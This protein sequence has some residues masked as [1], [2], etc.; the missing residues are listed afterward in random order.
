M[1]GFISRFKLLIQE[2][3]IFFF[4]SSGEGGKSQ[5]HEKGTFNLI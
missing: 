3:D 4:I 2:G 5:G 1:G